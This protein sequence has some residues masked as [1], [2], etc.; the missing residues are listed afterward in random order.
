MYTKL[1]INVFYARAYVLFS[2]NVFIF[3]M[4]ERG[5]VFNFKRYPGAK[6]AIKREERAR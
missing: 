2:R 1:K 3:P 4:K 5:D 6:K